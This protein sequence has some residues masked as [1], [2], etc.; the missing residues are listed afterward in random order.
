MFRKTVNPGYLQPARQ[1]RG[2]AFKGMF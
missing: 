1:I 2:L